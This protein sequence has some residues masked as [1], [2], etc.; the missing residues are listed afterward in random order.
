MPQN[1]PPVAAHIK[2]IKQNVHACNCETASERTKS[3][4]AQQKK[5]S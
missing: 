3:G 4:F 1:T 2:K 5:N